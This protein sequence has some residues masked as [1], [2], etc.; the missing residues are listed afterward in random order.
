MHQRSPKGLA[1]HASHSNRET[2][3]TAHTHSRNTQHSTHTEAQGR[4]GGG[5]V[6]VGYT[7]SIHTGIQQRYATA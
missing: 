2:Q 6:G 4:A 5:V 7:E 3:Y 1:S